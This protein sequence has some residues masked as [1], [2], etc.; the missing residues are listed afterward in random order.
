MDSKDNNFIETLKEHLGVEINDGWVL[1]KRNILFEG[2]DDI[3]YFNATFKGIMGHSLPAS[4]IS[5]DSS[6]NMPNFTEFINQKISNEKLKKGS[7]ICLLDNDDAGRKSFNQIKSKSF[8][9]PLK[10]VSMYLSSTDNKNDSY[11]SMMEDSIIPE[12]FFE[13]VLSFLKRKNTKFKLNKYSFSDF[14][15]ERKK[16]KRTPMPEFLDNYFDSEIKKFKNFS[17][18][19]LGIKFGLSLEYQEIISDKKSVD[20]NALK[21]KYGSLVHFLNKFI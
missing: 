1:Q 17:F 14:F 7:L 19:Y 6:Q 10:T 16:A 3:I 21:S 11:P 12:I 20:L 13:A 5:C 2:M 15:N 4:N 9:T 8:V 18:T